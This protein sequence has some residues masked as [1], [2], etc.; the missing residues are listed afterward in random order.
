MGED[1]DNVKKYL[2][3]V[4]GGLGLVMLVIAMFLRQGTDDAHTVI[5]N[6]AGTFMIVAGVICVLIGIIT[7]FLRNDNTIW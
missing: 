5:T 6:L 7:F 1:P 3:F 4:F 2:P